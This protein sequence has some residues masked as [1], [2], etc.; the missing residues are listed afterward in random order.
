MSIKLIAFD[1]DG[2]LL[3]NEHQ[4]EMETVETIKK[5][6]SKG[7]TTLTATGRMFCS[8]LPYIKQLNIKEAVI[9]YNGALVVDPVKEE[10][11][12]HDPI[13]LKT[14]R[15]IIE[16]A[17]NEGYY[18]QVYLDDRL[19]IEKKQEE[20]SIYEKTAGIKAEEVGSLNEFIKKPPTKLV[21]I[22]NDSKLH[23]EIYNK[24]SEK[25]ADRLEVTTS[26]NNFVEMTA[27]D[28]SKASALKKIA[29]K[30]S[31]NREE[32][33]A[34][35]DGLNDLKMLQWVGHGVAMENGHPELKENIKNIAPRNIELGAAKYLKA[36]FNL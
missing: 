10:V 29:D 17:A 21:I 27:R 7:I 9:N 2:T 4:L 3:N 35:G 11:I 5:L 20:T 13:P 24:L 1:L 16:F 8:A 14:A 25:F 22:E 26:I 30:L 15:E 34:F 31:V 32:I 6:Q 18:L 12:F 28:I 33:M 19:F 36:Y 23:K